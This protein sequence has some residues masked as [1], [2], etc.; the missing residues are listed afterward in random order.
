MGCLFFEAYLKR[1]TN[2][3]YRLILK[4]TMLLKTSKHLKGKIWKYQKVKKT[5]NTRRSSILVQ[6]RFSAEFIIYIII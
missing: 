5:R 4:T 1:L 6:K 3:D 2:Q